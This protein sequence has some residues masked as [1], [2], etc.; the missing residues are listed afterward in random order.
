MVS[1]KK[2]YDVYED[3]LVKVVRRTSN[4]RKDPSHFE[5]SL[6]KTE[7]STHWPRTL[8]LTVDELYDLVNVLD[9]L[10]DDIADGLVLGRPDSTT[11]EEHAEH[12]HHEGA[13]NPQG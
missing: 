3:D 4:G 2:T 10:C 12:E 13:P 5:V 6:A 7:G 8:K 9:D 1:G 11:G